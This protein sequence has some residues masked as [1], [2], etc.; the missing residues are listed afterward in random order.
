MNAMKKVFYEA[1]N[2]LCQF[3]IDKN[4][5]AKC[6]TLVGQKMHE[7]LVDCPSDQ[8]FDDCLMKFEIACSPW[9]MFVDYASKR[10]L[11]NNLGDLC[12]FW[13]AINNMITLQH[14]EIKASFET[15]TH[16]VRHVFKVTLYKR[17]IDMITA[18]FEHIKYV[19]IDNSRCVCIMRIT[20][21]LPCACELARYVL[22]S[23]PLDAIHMFRWRLSFSDQVNITEE[24]QAIS[25]QFEELD[26]CG[27][28][29]IK[30]KL[31][32]IFYHD[33]NSMYA[34]HEMDYVDTL[35]SV[36]N[37]NSSVKHCASSFE[38]PK[39]KRKMPMPDQ[40]HP[41]IHDFIENIVD[42]KADGN[43]VYRA[44]VG[45][46]EELKWLL[47]VDELS[48]V[49]MNKWMNITDMGCVHHIICIGHVYDN[50]FVQV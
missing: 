3:H 5:K 49:T 20:H 37:N 21:G 1:T 44:I 27:K 16:V 6:K 38:Q 46:Y 42:F 9:P 15:S 17:L 23:I 43:Y 13:G 39:P 14:I 8:E 24:I 34:P 10:L 32:E 33:L 2:L 30:S 12:S 50:H 11:Q 36:K 4:V 18:E 48:M 28:V 26:V 29:T 40:F 45:L 31:Q 25:R 22:G 41:C 7:S 47:L 35:H 19:D